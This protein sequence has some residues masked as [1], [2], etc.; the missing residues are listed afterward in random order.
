M[1]SNVG[2]D[3]RMHDDAEQREWLTRLERD[4]FLE[5]IGARLRT[6]RRWHAALARAA[7]RLFQDGEE[8]TDLRV[9]IAFALAESYDDQPEKSLAAAV[10]VILPIAVEELSASAPR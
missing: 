4:G 7:L 1:A 3:L 10:R 2:R 6:T 5:T 8:L 9:P